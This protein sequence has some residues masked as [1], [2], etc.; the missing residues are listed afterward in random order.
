MAQQICFSVVTD[1]T[2]FRAL[3][4]DWRNLCGRA[5]PTN[6]FRLFDWQWRAWQH[7]AS[8]QGCRLRILVGRIDARVVLIWPLVLDGP[9]LRF[10]CSEKFEYRDILVEREREAPAWIAA[11]WR[12]AARL[13]GGHALQLS[14]V[15]AGSVLGGFLD[16]STLRGLR[17]ELGSPVIRLDRFAGWEAYAAS[18]PKRLIADQKRQWRRLENMAGGYQFHIVSHAVEIDALV[19]WIF[20]HKLAWAAERSIS[21]GIYSKASYRTFIKDVLESYLASGRLLL[22]RLS[23]EDAILSAGFGFV[24]P[25]RFIFYMFAYDAAY[26]GL[27]PS[28]LLMERMIRWCMECGLASF[29]FLPG[30]EPVQTCLGRRGGGGRRLSH[31][32]Y[33]A[34]ALADRLDPARDKA[35]C[36]ARSANALV[37]GGAATSA[38]YAPAETS[39]RFGRDGGHAANQALNIPINAHMLAGQSV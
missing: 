6:V 27:S 3:E 22:C 20:T 28:R 10:L 23:V 16:G 1:A 36:V 19:D 7:I 24:H 25:E 4:A 26:G 31:P 17:R 15:P 32:S 33:T 34:W 35:A 5:A 30:P 14:D 2:K 13:P 38:R 37:P 18:L 12:H 9:L 11:A 8:V 21:T 39:R 29:D